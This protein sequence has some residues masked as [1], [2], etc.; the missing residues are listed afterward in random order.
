MQ[1]HG[2]DQQ[3]AGFGFVPLQAVGHLLALLLTLLLVRL[4]R[5]V[6]LVEVAGALLLQLVHHALQ[7]FLLLVE[8]LLIAGDGFLQAGQHRRWVFDLGKCG[9]RSLRGAVVLDGHVH[10]QLV[11]GLQ[12]QLGIAQIALG[13]VG[14]VVALDAQ[15]VDLVHQRLADAIN[16][17]RVFHQVIEARLRHA[18]QQFFLVDGFG[19]LF[20]EAAQ[21]G[22]RTARIDVQYS[23]G[24]TGEVG[25]QL[26]A[27]AEEL[28]VD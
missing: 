23:L 4:G 28:E 17:H 7:R 26:V 13:T 6:D 9:D 25:Q 21:A 11:G 10:G 12:G 20:G 3:C 27:G 18:R 24:K 22:E 15:E 5:R 19:Q 1:E 14:G 8:F 16:K 2:V